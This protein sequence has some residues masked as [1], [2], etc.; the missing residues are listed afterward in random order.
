MSPTAAK[1]ARLDTRIT[2]ELQGELRLVAEMQ[3]RS[4]SDYVTAALQSAVRRDIAEMTAIRLSRAASEAFAAALLDP[5][6]PAEALRRA[7]AHRRR[8]IRPE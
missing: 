4:V 2:P 3:G 1:S 5:P 7:F 8:L 6:P